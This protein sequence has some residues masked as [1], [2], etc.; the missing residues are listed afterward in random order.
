MS[1]CL[2]LRDWKEAKFKMIIRIVRLIFIIKLR[3][4]ISHLSSHIKNVVFSAALDAYADFFGAHF[5]ARCEEGNTNLL[6]KITSS[7]LFGA[8]LQKN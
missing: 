7:L 3:G 2:L 4:K 6:T 8:E 5:T 1:S